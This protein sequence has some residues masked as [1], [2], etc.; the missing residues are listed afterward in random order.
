MQLFVVIPDNSN[1]LKLR[2]FSETI[3]FPCDGTNAAVYSDTFD[4]SKRMREYSLLKNAAPSFFWSVV[5]YF[6]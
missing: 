3:L 5:L 6:I 1:Y 4:L 2:F